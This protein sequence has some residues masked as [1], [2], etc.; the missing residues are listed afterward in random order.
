MGRHSS[1]LSNNFLPS[2]RKSP[3]I[4][5]MDEPGRKHPAHPALHEG[6]NTPAIVFLTICTADRK[7][8]LE[9]KGAHSTLREAWQLAKS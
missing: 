6:F 7:R 2:R 3:Q 8:V 9:D 4:L 1:R 5:L